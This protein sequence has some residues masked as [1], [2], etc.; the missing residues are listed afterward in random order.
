MW[1]VQGIL[2]ALHERERTGKGRREAEMKDLRA[3]RVL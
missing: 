3:K 1:A 2:A